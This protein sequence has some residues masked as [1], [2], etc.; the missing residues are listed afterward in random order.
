[1]ETYLLKGFYPAIS[2]YPTYLE[3]PSTEEDLGTQL[4]NKKWMMAG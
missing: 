4:R 3:G 1:M 2:I